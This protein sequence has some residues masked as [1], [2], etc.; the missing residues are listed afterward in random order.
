MCVSRMVFAYAFLF[1]FRKLYG[2][3]P[4]RLV[5]QLASIIDK[6][7]EIL[8]GCILLGFTKD[9]NHLSK[10]GDKS[11]LLTTSSVSYSC[12][13]DDRLSADATLRHHYRVQFWLFR[14]ASPLRKCAEVSLFGSHREGIASWGTQARLTIFQSPDERFFVAHCIVPSR[15]P[16]DSGTSY[17]V[18]CWL[19][20]RCAR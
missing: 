15:A 7:R 4:K 18:C 17:A 20:C 14:Y 16:D 2:S 13:A 8:N 19:Q 1:P 10:R 9:G 5:I 12:A 3:V 11:S 6:D